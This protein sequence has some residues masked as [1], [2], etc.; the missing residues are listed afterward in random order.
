MPDVEMLATATRLGGGILPFDN[1]PQYNDTNNN[2]D[3]IDIDIDNIEINN[4]S[5]INNNNN[6]HNMHNINF[7]N[8]NSHMENDHNDRNRVSTISAA[9]TTAGS[10]PS[11]PAPGSELVVVIMLPAIF[12]VVPSGLVAS[13]A[14]QEAI[15]V[16]DEVAARTA[17]VATVAIG[18]AD[19]AFTVIIRAV[20]VAVGIAAGWYVAEFACRLPRK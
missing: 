6:I 19:P 14:L 18:T 10:I 11:L 2:I 12:I 17:S 8:I 5:N 15:R 16:A 4:I 7:I 13:G 9:T 1:P 20:V 3:D